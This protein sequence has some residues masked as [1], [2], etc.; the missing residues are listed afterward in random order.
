LQPEYV[1]IVIVNISILGLSKRR[2]V[3]KVVLYKKRLFTGDLILHQGNNLIKTDEGPAGSKH[4]VEQLLWPKPTSCPALCNC[5]S[6]LPSHYW[7]SRSASFTHPV[8]ANSDQ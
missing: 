6:G 4:K 1:K 5:R 3:N 8:S 2:F 7:N